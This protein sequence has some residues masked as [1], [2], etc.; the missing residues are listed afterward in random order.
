MTIASYAKTEVTASM[1]NPCSTCRGGSLQTH[2]ARLA[3]SGW[4]LLVQSARAQHL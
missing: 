2:S 4:L 1:H 3:A